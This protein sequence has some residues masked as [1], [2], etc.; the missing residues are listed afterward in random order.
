MFNDFVVVH[1]SGSQPHWAE[2]NLENG[3]YWRTCLRTILFCDSSAL[4]QIPQ[5]KEV[6][7]YK[8]ARAY[9]FILQVICGLH[10]PIPG[11]TE[12]F[13][14]FRQLCENLDLPESHWGVEIK[15]IFEHL[16]VDCKKVRK[17]HLTH[18]GANSYGSYVR[19]KSRG[20]E[21]V[22]FLGAGLLVQDIWPWLKKEPVTQKIF[23]RNPQKVDFVSCDE[24]HH[25]EVARLSELPDWPVPEKSLLVVAAPLKAQEI[26]DLLSDFVKNFRNI[27]DLR[28][29]SESDSLPKNW[30]VEKLNEVFASFE[31]YKKQCKERLLEASSL[32]QKLSHERGDRASLRPFGWDDLWS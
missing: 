30:P 3:I 22:Y 9:E 11:E 1:S 6:D 5:S 28:G 21:S 20:C 4:E 17:A 16:I 7:I 26:Q 15:E 18:L 32:I 13:G 31:K 10:S 23:C 25:V 2:F 24:K 19:R 29:T 14:Q 8:N 12:I 27:I